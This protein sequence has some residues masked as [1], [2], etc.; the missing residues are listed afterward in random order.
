MLLIIK[1]K[2]TDKTARQQ[3]KQQKEKDVKY[4]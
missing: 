4:V 3:K 2:E 1:H